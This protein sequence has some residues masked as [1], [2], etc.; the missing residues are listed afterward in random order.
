MEFAMNLV[1]VE[2]TIV[3]TE[4]RFVASITTTYEISGFDRKPVRALIRDREGWSF[5]CALE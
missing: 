2:S 4:G 3:N 5:K 1:D